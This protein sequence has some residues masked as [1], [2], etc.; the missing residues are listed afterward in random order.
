MEEEIVTSIDRLIEEN[1]TNHFKIL[2]IIGNN[3][4]KINNLIEY[5]RKKGW[6]IYDVEKI[7]F[8]LVNKIPADKVKLRIGAEIKKWIKNT[9]DR[10]VLYNA[11]ILYSEEM[12][13]L[14]PFSA[15]KYHMRGNQEGILFMD[16]KLRGN[17]V[18]YSTPDRPDY[19][20]RELSDVV[21]IDLE[22]VEL[23]GE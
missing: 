5:L 2:T 1:R 10:I 17:E 13:N 3:Q 20:K 22:N 11:N 9:E 16:G 14:G 21:Y 4:V 6:V 8:E 18:I 7:I 23:P 19:H 15:F 12:D